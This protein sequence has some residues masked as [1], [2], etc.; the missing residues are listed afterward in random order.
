MTLPANSISI[1]TFSPRVG[2]I[3][4]ITQAEQALVTI[5]AP[6]TFVVG[7]S[8]RIVIPPAIRA[9]P[10]APGYDYGMHEINGMLA[11]I[12]AIPTN[13]TFQIDIDTRFFQPF[14]V[15][16]DFNQFAQAVPVGEQNSMLDGAWRNILPPV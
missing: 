8:V 15:P 14:T 3:I 16:A 12:I 2:I 9:T 11:N 4:A 6:L 10:S 5:L 7:Q 1:P 13:V